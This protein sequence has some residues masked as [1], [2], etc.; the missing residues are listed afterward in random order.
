MRMPV[1][2]ASLNSSFMMVPRGDGGGIG[3]RLLDVRRSSMFMMVEVG[4]GGRNAIGLTASWA[5]RT[6]EGVAGFDCGCRRR[7]RWAEW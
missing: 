6:E 7:C 5:A 3:E 4:S 2:S 1:L